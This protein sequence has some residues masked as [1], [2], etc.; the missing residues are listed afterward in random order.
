MYNNVNEKEDCHLK[1]KGNFYEKPRVH[2]IFASMYKPYL[3]KVHS[4]NILICY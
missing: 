1:K 3:N 2:K 4:K